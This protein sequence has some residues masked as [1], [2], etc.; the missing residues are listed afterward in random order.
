MAQFDVYAN[1][2]KSQR[3]DIPWCVDI[4][5]DLLA[6]LSTRLVIPLASRKHTPAVSPRRLC[7][8]VQ[9]EGESF[10][11]LPQMAA[12]FRTRDLGSAHGSLRSHASELV[13]SIDAV[14]S[15]I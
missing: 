5:S 6:S 7:P 15:G 13:A 1:P 14:I 9:W 3:E 10:V 12:P 11:A 8:V 4:Q 2:V